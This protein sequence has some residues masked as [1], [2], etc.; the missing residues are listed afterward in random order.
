[1]PAQLLADPNETV[2]V[3]DR[4]DVALLTRILLM[5]IFMKKPDY[6]LWNFILND[7]KRRRRSKLNDLPPELRG[8]PQNKY[9]GHH[10]QRMRPLRGSTFGPANEGRTLTPDE[11]ARVEDELRE[12][13]QL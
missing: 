11:I 9:G 8:L 7:G 13:G 1:L 12:K 5:E 6:A 2:V 10:G 3:S 4:S